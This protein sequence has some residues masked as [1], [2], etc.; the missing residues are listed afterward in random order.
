MN[1]Q[2]YPKN[3]HTPKIVIFLKTPKNIEIQIFEPPKMTR[4][5]V[6]VKNIR[7][8]PWDL[9]C[10]LYWSNGYFQLHLSEIGPVFSEKNV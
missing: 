10:L 5:Y 9:D 7:V 6:C 2:K 4:A 3:L 8:P 1:P